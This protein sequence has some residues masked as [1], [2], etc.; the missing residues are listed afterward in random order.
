[1]LKLETDNFGTVRFGGSEGSVY[2]REEGRAQV[3]K[4]VGRTLSGV[5]EQSPSSGGEWASPLKWT[6][7]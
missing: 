2:K 1:M 4:P 3:R 6:W 5:Q 7:T